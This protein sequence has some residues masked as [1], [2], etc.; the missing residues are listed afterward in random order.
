MKRYRALIPIVL[1]VLMAVSWYMMIN[2]AAKVD[3]SYNN[4]LS[5]AR[6]WAN[7][8]IMKYAI[9]NYNAALRIKDTPEIYTPLFIGSIVGVAALIGAII[10]LIAKKKKKDE[11]VSAK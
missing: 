11:T 7:E 8:G 3:N 5:E 9:E 10:F 1:V 6:R 2:N 4:Y